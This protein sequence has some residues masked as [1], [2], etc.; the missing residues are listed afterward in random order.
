MPQAPGLQAAD[1][2]AWCVSHRD[3]ASLRWH[4]E[5]LALPRMDEWIDYKELIKPIPGVASLVA[6][7][8]LPKRRAT[9]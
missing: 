5:V 7:W 2:F 4:K 8:K 6:S 3:S 1:L 9:R